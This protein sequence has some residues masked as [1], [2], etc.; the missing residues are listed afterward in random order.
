M[1]PTAFGNAI[2]TG[3]AA[4][5]L[6]GFEFEVCIPKKSIESA[7]GKT[8]QY[9][10]DI[11]TWISGKS[12]SDLLDGIKSKGYR[13]FD[14]LTDILKIKNS[15]ALE[16]NI[17]IDIEYTYKSWTHE[18][19]RKSPEYSIAGYLKFVKDT[20]NSSDFQEEL[21][22]PTG[23][24]ANVPGFARKYKAI[25][26]LD[27][28]KK[29]NKWTGKDFTNHVLKLATGMDFTGDIQPESITPQ[30]EKKI[31]DAMM[32]CFYGLSRPFDYRMKRLKVDSF[33][34][35]TEE[36]YMEMWTKTGSDYNTFK[37]KFIE[38]C[39][40]VLGSDD[41]K[42]LLKTKLA[43]YGRTNN[44]TGALKQ[45]LWYFIT[46]DAQVP[47]VLNRGTV[48][49]SDKYRRGAE[50]V[51][52]NMKSLLGDNSVIF[53]RYHERTKDMT[54]WYIEPDGSLRPDDQDS[55]VEIVSPPLAANEA[56]K[57]LNKFYSEATKLKLYT[58]TDNRTGL[59][60]NVSI[61]QTLDVVKLALFMGDIHVL[62]KFD[63]FEG[64]HSRYS[65]SI[66]RQLS[67]RVKNDSVSL[68]SFPDA[69]ETIQELVDEISGEHTTSINYNG[70]YISFRHAGGNYLGRYKDIYQT[71]GRFIHAMIIAS[72][73]TMYKREYM[74][75]LG[76][77]LSR[78]MPDGSTAKQIIRANKIP[79]VYND[80]ALRLSPKNRT[81]DA[82]THVRDWM[83]NASTGRYG[84]EVLYIPVIKPDPSARQ[85]IL[86]GKGFASDSKEAFKQLPDYAFYRITFYP[87][88]AYGYSRAKNKIE[89]PDIEADSKA[90]TIWGNSGDKIAGGIPSAGYID[91][92]DPMFIKSYNA[93]V[94]SN[95]RNTDR[96]PLPE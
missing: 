43:F 32:E 50:F 25:R 10:D 21:V 85:R 3:D 52:E 12:M 27:T 18:Q 20:L 28:G 66:I 70:K 79:V 91:R 92:S 6:V 9:T 69:Q 2:T 87:I 44:T 78:N 36:K 26:T 88:D 24:G 76:Q 14:T 45:K 23:D 86:K 68:D 74:T 62:K 77:M 29:T 35:L 38:F 15:V 8:A 11:D 72:T 37:P 41:L 63:R 16:D 71:V 60:I 54:T 65:D 83:K 56:M 19:I 96:L 82:L 13:V 94:S 47:D 30:I 39:T 5:V 42:T 17:S 61:P 4:G 75:K 33:Y 53:N 31:N 95:D 81:N 84:G 80:I 55:A 59:H 48:S 73:P 49:N 7:G 90:F 1:T 46:P 34:E 89:N 51:K 57:A 67:T 64:D 40:T 22:I 58:G 93:L